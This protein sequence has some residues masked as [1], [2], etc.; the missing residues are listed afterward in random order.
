MSVRK[1]S[2]LDALA[3]ARDEAPPRGFEQSVDLT[4][5]LR[6]LDMRRPD[7]RVNLRIQVPHG[8]GGQKVLVFAS[9]D[10]ALRARRAGADRVVE[11]AELSEMGSDRKEAKRRLKDYDIFVAEA[12]LMPTVGRVAGPI[13]GPRGKM[14][15]PVPPQAPIDAILER[16]R[17]TVILRSRERSFVKCKVGKESMPDE[18]IV[19]NVEAVLGSLYGALKRGES[20]VKSI[21]LKLT[22]GPA[23][24]V[25]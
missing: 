9:G 20:N 23:V 11:P 5:N 2:I 25:E 6:D 7:N 17:R 8:V 16:E 1:D 15:T 24:K 14:P 22:M 19:E 13:L 4:V 10:L 3:K 12:P 21:Y 18:E